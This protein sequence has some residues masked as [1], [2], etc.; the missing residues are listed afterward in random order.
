M[1]SQEFGDWFASTYTR[2]KEIGS[3]ARNNLNHDVVLNEIMYRESFTTIPN[4]KPKV[5]D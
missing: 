1:N 3:V 4:A 5:H 2:G